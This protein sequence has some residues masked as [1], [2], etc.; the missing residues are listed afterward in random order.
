MHEVASGDVDEDAPGSS[1]ALPGP[2]E[3]LERSE[4][5]QRLGAAIEALPEAARAT[6]LLREV[7]GLSY[8]EIARTLGIPKGT[9]MSRLHYARR[10]VQETLVA[11]G[12][13]APQP[14]T[15]RDGGDPQGGEQ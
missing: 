8:G 9:V 7:D 13:E 2:D 14:R 1:L 11:M 12:E 3:M 10:R 15:R 4:L 6:L 5:R